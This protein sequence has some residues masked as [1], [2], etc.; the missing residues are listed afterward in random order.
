MASVVVCRL[1]HSLEPA[2][3]CINVPHHQPSTN[4]PMEVFET[5]DPVAS[6][7][8]EIITPVCTCGR[9]K[10]CVTLLGSMLELWIHRLAGAAE[11]QY[12]HLPCIRQNCVPAI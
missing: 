3:V 12:R 9:I 2:N 6:K 8:E 4:V 1:S 10:S 11:C 5:P 7:Q